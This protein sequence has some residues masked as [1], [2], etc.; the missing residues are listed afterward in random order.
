MPR[1]RAQWLL[2]G[3]RSF[4]LSAKQYDAFLAALDAVSKPRLER[5]AADV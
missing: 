3:R 2:T 1:Q 5:I 4:A